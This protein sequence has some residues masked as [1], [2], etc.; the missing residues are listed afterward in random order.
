[1][2]Q[3][4]GNPNNPSA[5][6][7][8]STAG[9]NPPETGSVNEFDKGYGKGAD[10]G[11]REVLQALG[12]NSLEE[13]QKAQSAQKEADKK[14]LEEQNKYKELY[15]QTTTEFADYKARTK[16]FIPYVW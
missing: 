14:A 16:L 7:A 13:A 1:M 4:Q 10:K 9:T 5:S 11:R 12:F 2:T 6:E 8:Q 3:E 15:E